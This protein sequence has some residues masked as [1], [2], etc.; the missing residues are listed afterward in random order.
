MPTKARPFHALLPLCPSMEL[1]S[2]MPPAPENYIIRKSATSSHHPVIF[3][4]RGGGTCPFHTRS[5]RPATPRGNGD[6]S[7]KSKGKPPN[8]TKFT[9]LLRRE[10]QGSLVPSKICGE[11]VGATEGQTARRH[12][13]LTH[14]PH[15]ARTPLPQHAAAAARHRCSTPPPN[16]GMQI[17]CGFV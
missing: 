1:L 12:R 9:S 17:R 11:G 13:Y 10:F 14:D 7:A 8:P 4:C 3:R 16:A 6:E 5:K 2:S 15:T